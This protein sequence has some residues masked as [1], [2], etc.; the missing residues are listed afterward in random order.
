MNKETTTSKQ[1]HR[2]GVQRREGER[3]IG[4]HIQWWWDRRGKKKKSEIEIVKYTQYSTN[5]TKQKTPTGCCKRMHILAAHY[6]ASLHGFN[7]SWFV[8]FSSFSF[9]GES[10]LDSCCYFFYYCCGGPTEPRLPKPAQNEHQQHPQFF[11]LARLSQHSC[12]SLN[13]ALRSPK[14]P[15]ATGCPALLHILF[16]DQDLPLL[17]TR[18]S[19]TGKCL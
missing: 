1:N 12:G 16:S 19:N 18:S 6:R 5:K 4:S 13:P 8:L 3:N 17:A 7:H 9:L 11:I 15:G 2:K 10:L 14:Q